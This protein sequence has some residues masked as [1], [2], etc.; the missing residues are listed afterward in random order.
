MLYSQNDI[1]RI[2]KE[3]NIRSIRLAFCDVYGTEK[4]ISITPEE[5]K[6]AFDRGIP[7]NASAIPYFG[8]GVY[9]DLL[10]HP[11]PDTVAM[12]PWRTEQDKVLRIFCSMTYPDGRPLEDRGTKSILMKAI[13]E[14]E[15]EGVEFYF[16]S[17]I[18]FYLLKLDSHGRPTDE[19]CDEAGYLDVAP[20][21][22]CET[23]RR[24]IVMA[25]EEMGIKVQNSF[26]EAGPGQNEIDFA[27]NT[28]LTAGNDIVTAKLVIK[29]AAL[30]NG[31]YADFTPKPLPHKPG[32]GFHINVSVRNNDGTDRSMDNV[33]AGVLE[34]I[35]EMTAFMNPTEQ[36][37]GRLMQKATPEYVSWS[38]EYRAQLLRIPNNNLRF[39]K[40]ELRSPDLMSNPY[41]DFA[42]IINAGLYGIRNHLIL[43]P[44]SNFDLDTAEPDLLAGYKKLPRNIDEARKIARES[45]FIQSTVSHDIF[46]IYLKTNK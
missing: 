19:P 17:E 46:R 9:T 13:R 40:A 43:P 34:K 21:D 14:A 5:I 32:N 6:T 11:E 28:P 8:E 24:D 42:M 3:E 45:T 39:R 29:N 35:C 20:D 44:P 16:G 26:H 36:S 22:R 12:L 1:M 4:N 37:Y 10:L 33:V 41:L 7:I 23:V 15:E 2:I 31:L 25:L 30:R 27:Y 38:S 18:E